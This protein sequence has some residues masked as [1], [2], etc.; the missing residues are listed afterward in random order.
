MATLAEEKI[1]LYMKAQKAFNDDATPA[2]IKIV[3]EGDSWFDYPF[4]K[5]V[6]DHL[7]KKGYAVSKWSKAGD[8]LEN[9]AYGVKDSTME[10]SNVLASIKL[11][12]P[13][14]VIL[15]AGGNDVVGQ[16]I[17]HYLNHINSNLN[18]FRKDIFKLQMHGAVKAAIER[19]LYCIWQVD[20]NV[21]V[22]MHGYDYAKPNGT[23]YEI[24]GFIGVKGP[25][26]L[27]AF[28]RKGIDDRT[29]QENIIKEMVDIFNEML[30]SLANSNP[31]FHYLDLR[32]EFPGDSEWD[33]ELH[34]K[35]SGFKKVADYFHEKIVS[36]LGT[37]PITSDST[38]A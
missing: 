24:L 22:I 27:P 9:M 10:L 33:N 3:A 4:N 35:S 15:S 5:D 32:G 7:I 38:I 12:K 23:K 13:G 2:N 1:Q 25:W 11:L 16:Q 18:L 37:D 36:I 14:F 20:S 8:T 17:T 26:I 28:E 29:V 30:A 31:N 34:L 6:V 21:Q 19:I